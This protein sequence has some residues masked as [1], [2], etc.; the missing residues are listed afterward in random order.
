MG[1]HHKSSSSKGHGKSSSSKKAVVKIN[2]WYCDAC[3]HGPWNT[4][5]DMHCP[6]CRHQRCEGCMADMITQRSD[7]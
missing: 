7:H 2:V 3:R 5:I 1:S 4:Y 6:N